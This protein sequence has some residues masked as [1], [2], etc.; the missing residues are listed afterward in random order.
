MEPEDPNAVLRDLGRRVAELRADLGLT[1]EALAEKLDVT[2]QYLQRIEAGREN[3]TVR[4]IVR[5]AG[6]LGVPT[7]GLFE[8][9]KSREVRVGRPA[10]RR[11]SAQTNTPA[12]I[13]SSNEDVLETPIKSPR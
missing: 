4:S 2:F 11:Q 8:A 10:G 3:L 6:E 13:A 1:Q 7:S 9:P 12:N 5:L